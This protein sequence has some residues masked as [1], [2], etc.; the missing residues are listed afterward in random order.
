MGMLNSA[1]TIRATIRGVPA[2]ETNAA[3]GFSTAARNGGKEPNTTVTT[4]TTEL[5]ER[6]V[7]RITPIA[8]PRA[9]RFP[10]LSPVTKRTAIRR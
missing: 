3:S 9:L 6:T 1:E 7:P 5:K 10:P 8:S 4:L 2:W